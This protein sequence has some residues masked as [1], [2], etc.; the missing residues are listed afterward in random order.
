MTYNS[1]KSKSKANKIILVSLLYI[2]FIFLLN[3]YLILYYSPLSGLC[4]FVIIFISGS[5][6]YLISGSRDAVIKIIYFSLLAIIVSYLML[7]IAAIMTS[8]GQYPL[9][10][11]I[12]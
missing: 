5:V 8:S 1:R 9:G 6:Y 10:H 4:L 12:K 3:S 11:I 7:E 2:V